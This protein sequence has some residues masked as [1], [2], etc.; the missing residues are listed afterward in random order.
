MLLIIYLFKPVK[1]AMSNYI[2]FFYSFLLFFA[3]FYPVF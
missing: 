2:L 1:L 3:V